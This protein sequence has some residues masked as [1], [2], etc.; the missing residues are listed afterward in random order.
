MEPAAEAGRRFKVYLGPAGIPGE[1]LL[2]RDDFRP[3][4]VE[5][6]RV[7][8]SGAPSTTTLRTN[9][10]LKIA[11]ESGVQASFE[12]GVFSSPTLVLTSYSPT[13]NELVVVDPLAEI[14]G[15]KQRKEWLTALVL[16]VAYFEALAKRRLAARLKGVLDEQSIEHLQATPLA[17][18]LYGTEILAQQ[19]FSKAVAV[20]QRRNLILHPAKE[21][22][23]PRLDENEGETLVEQSLEVLR[24]LAS[25]LT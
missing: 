25:G 15:A 22:V 13:R 2:L 1:D 11:N 17:I 8:T 5:T 6:I 16:C 12:V 19:D 20:I 10:S 7:V 4:K 9:Y 24:K 21:I 14:E 18:L 23:R 3:R